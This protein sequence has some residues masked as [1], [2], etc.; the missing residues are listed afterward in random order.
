MA[1]SCVTQSVDDFFAT[2]DPTIR[3]IYEAFV[4]R[5][6]AICG[7]VLV[8]VNK[9]RISLQIRTRFASVNGFTKEGLKVHLVSQKKL[10]SP[11]FTKTEKFD[12]AYVHNFILRSVSDI[13]DEV[14]DWIKEAYKYGEQN[15]D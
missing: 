7:K 8:N 13:D 2:A 12:K 4:K 10:P 6:E 3:E 14:S 1:H 5:V 11:R 15:S 9:T